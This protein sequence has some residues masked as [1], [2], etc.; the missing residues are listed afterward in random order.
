MKFLFIEIFSHGNLLVAHQ[1]SRH[2]PKA[3]RLPLPHVSAG[4]LAPRHKDGAPRGPADL[5]LGVGPRPAPSVT[6]RPA[7]AFARPGTAPSRSLGTP[8][9]PLPAAAAVCRRPRRRSELAR[10][11]R[12]KENTPLQ[13]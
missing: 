7:L 9:V 13:S 6:T 12:G 2:A 10:S 8:P 4:A 11:H 5:A 3:R 1:F